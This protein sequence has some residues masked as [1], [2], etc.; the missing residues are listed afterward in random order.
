MRTCIAI[1]YQ[2]THVIMSIYTLVSY[3]LVAQI[4]VLSVTTLVADCWMAA[5]NFLTM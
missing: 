3:G 2:K 1:A 4:N 5:L